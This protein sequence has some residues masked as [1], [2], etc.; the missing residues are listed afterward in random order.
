MTRIS[1]TKFTLGCMLLLITR[2]TFA[3]DNDLDHIE[4]VLDQL[5]QKLIDQESDGL[6]YGEKSARNSRKMPEKAAKSIKLK[7]ET[8]EGKTVEA[9][10]I[11][12]VNTLLR[13]LEQRVEQFAGKVQ[14]AKQQVLE[15]AK[16]DNLINIDTIL[17]NTD[18]FAINSLTIR[19]D[20]Q[21]VYT[22]KD[23][24]GVWMP[25]KTLPI[26]S[27][28]LEPGM[29]RLDFEARIVMK[30]QDGLP[31]N[32]DLYKFISQSY[33]LPIRQ[34]TKLSRYAVVLTPPSE[35]TAQPVAIL[36]DIK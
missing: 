28:P 26:Y 11:D 6:T 29:H 7:T 34:D 12:D 5:E 21:A 17:E 35:P 33:D 23:S 20:G 30:S 18:K 32:S 2:L 4:S 27:G 36:K 1:I 9:K 19:L 8:L 25:N 31:L 16:I 22:L 10:R 13:D 15:A 14:I 24:S 3:K